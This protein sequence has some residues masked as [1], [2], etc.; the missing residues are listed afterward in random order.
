MGS[1]SLDDLA[2]QEDRLARRL[3][4]PKASGGDLLALVRAALVAR[5]Y[6]SILTDSPGLRPIAPVMWANHGFS[7][8][9]PTEWKAT[10]WLP[11]WLDHHSTPP[12][13]APARKAVRRRDWRLG[14]DRFYQEATDRDDYLSAGQRDA[15]R[16]VGAAQP[17]DSVICVLPTGSGKTDVILSRAISR[18]PKQTCLV[19]PTVALALDVERRVSEMT[20]EHHDLAYHSGLSAEAKSALAD[21]VREG[22][23][24]LVI[25][26]PEAACTVLARPLEKAAADG[27][28]D[29]V[30]IDEAHIIAEWGDD[31]RPAFHSLAGLRTRL[32]ETAPPGKQPTTVMLTATLDDHAFATLQRLFPG[33]QE[34]LVSAQAT[35]PEPAWWA[36]EC[37]DEDEKRRR[38]IEACRRLPRPLLVYTTLHTSERS[39]NVGTALSW[40][41]AAGFHAIAGVTGSSTAEQRK[42]VVRRLNLDGDPGDDL[43]VVVATSAFG[44]G[45]D[46]P[47]IRAVV[48][49]CVPESVDR[50]YQE[51]GRA[52]R[53]GKAAASVVLWTQADAR[54][55][56]QMSEAR[57][58][59]D[60]KAWK[61]WT[62]MRLGAA[63]GDRLEV[64]LTAATDDV[65]Y[66]WSDAN[67]YWNL[68]TLSGMDRAGMISLDWPTPP[69]VPADVSDD[70][71]Q[72]IF[73][74]HRRSTAVRIKQS[75]LGNERAFRA[76]FRAA[77]SSSRGAASAS[78]R[79]AM[80]LLNGTPG[81]TNSFL[82]THYRLHPESGLIA[83]V[84]Q[85]G[86]CPHCRSAGGQPIAEK[87][88][89]PPLMAG[90][91][92]VAARPSLLR[93]AENGKLCIWTD[94][95]QDAEERELVRRLHALG[96]LVFASDDDT[97]ALPAGKR[98]WWERK[99]T[100]LGD[101][102]GLDVSTLIAIR[103]DA[104]ALGTAEALSKVTRSP[105]AVVLTTRDHPS[106]FDD[107]SLL[108]EA[109]GSS[110]YINDILRRL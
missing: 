52:G 40:L 6:G 18:R 98:L 45:I 54:V 92:T 106:P 12:D 67:R 94:D 65:T 3:T 61:R 24:W 17:G 36:S 80:T 68:Q 110:Y 7:P 41:T 33:A 91:L 51:V 108:R 60:E 88:S 37:T 93:L 38:F 57:L 46:I 69:D 47:G 97:L 8:I 1:L 44:L 39:T 35:R 27:R 10:P 49:L 107:R 78:L 90:N 86:G 66:P 64:D 11:E 75:N 25:T 101:D 99:I 73:A 72:E 62:A 4:D 15:V 74:A 31:F 48:H 85:C 58:I 95:D 20:G 83:S 21:R 34:L 16:A 29:L 76:Q 26:S 50:L 79:S 55:A 28:L 9:G 19:V 89:V 22:T 82:A 102:E 70:V 43:D 2:A 105:L 59:G 77:Q 13:E 5:G 87:S 42:G 100:E 103:R 30:A 53:D 32:I 56:R 84:R 104:R 23:Q 109:W 71:M 63:T 96:V 14:A 81:C